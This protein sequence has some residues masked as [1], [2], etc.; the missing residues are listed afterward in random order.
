MTPIHPT[1]IVDPKAEID[2]SVEIGPYVIIE[3]P[4]QIGPRTKIFAHAHLCGNTVIGADNEIHMGC[5]IGHTP[6]HLG[7]RGQ[8]TGVRIGDGNVFREYVTIHRGS[9][10]G[11]HTVVGDRCYFMAMSHIAHDAVVGNEIIVANGTLLAGHVHIEDKVVLSGN[12]GIHQHCRIGTLAMIGGLS[13]IV[14]DIPPYMLVDGSSKVCGINV[15]G[16]RRAGFDASTREKI[17]RAYKLL[18]RSNLNVSQALEAI[19][20]ELGDCPQIQHLIGFIRASKRGIASHTLNR[21]DD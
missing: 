20:Q 17:K 4:V 3:G 7:Y 19:E 11:S 8:P 13:K 16:L 21:S 18:Y 15:V 10:E 1:A 14:Q 5:V 9:E 12:V 6:Q 2:P